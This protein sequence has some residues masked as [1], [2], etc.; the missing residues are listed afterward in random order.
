MNELIYILNENGT[1]KG[2]EDRKIVHQNG[3]L[4][5]GIVCWIINEENKVLIQ[6]RSKTKDKSPNKWD[7]SFGGHCSKVDNI[8]DIWIENVLKEGKEELGLNLSIDEII[9]LG[10]IRY[11]SQ[12]NKNN[13]LLKIFLIRKNK[14]QKFIFEDGEVSDIKWIDINDLKENILNNKDEYA[15]RINA[16]NLLIDYLKNKEKIC[17]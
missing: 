10:K 6:K 4:H 1:I 14:N 15:N 9:N 16:L 11:V 3:I 12:E 5:T 7:V 8:K 2:L 13:E 17:V